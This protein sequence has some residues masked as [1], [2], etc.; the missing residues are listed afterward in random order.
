MGVVRDALTKVINPAAYAAVKSAAF[1]LGGDVPWQMGQGFGSSL[2]MWPFLMPS[3]RL[4]YTQEAGDPSQNSIIMSCCLWIMRTFPE[5]PIR[6]ID[7]STPGEEDE[8]PRHPMV[9]L[10]ERPNA[11]YNGTLLWQAS[12]LSW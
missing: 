8:I 6:V 1:A 5:A 11:Y 9:R 3:T 10:I 12:T 7:V 4:D 2:G